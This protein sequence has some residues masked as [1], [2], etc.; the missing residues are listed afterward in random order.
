MTGLPYTFCFQMDGSA[1]PSSSPAFAPAYSILSPFLGS[2][3]T[4]ISF[5][6]HWPTNHWDCDIRGVKIQ[7]L[8]SGWGQV[9][10]MHD[11]LHLW[12]NS[13]VLGASSVDVWSSH[14]W[15]S[16]FLIFVNIGWIIPLVPILLLGLVLMLHS[17]TLLSV[18]SS[19]SYWGYYSSFCQQWCSISTQIDLQGR[20]REEKSKH[21]CF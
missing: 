12:S 2:P 6:F 17:E 14:L 7:I 19:K 5:L 8:N 18:T 20:K 10:W 3:D 15:S 1:Y 16:G 9:R 4:V 11:S 13:L 21:S